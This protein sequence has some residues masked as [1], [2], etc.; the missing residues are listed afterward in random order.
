MDA[1]AELTRPKKGDIFTSVDARGSLFAPPLALELAC[2]MVMVRKAGKLRSKRVVLC[3]NLL[4]T[5]GTLEV[6]ARL[7][8]QCSG[9]FAGAICLIKLTGPR[10]RARLDCPVAALQTYE[11]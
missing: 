5:S 9:I 4:A 1:F 3:D 2:G 11:F 7:I 6:T 10:R 8:E